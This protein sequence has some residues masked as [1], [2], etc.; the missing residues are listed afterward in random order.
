MLIIVVHCYSRRYLCLYFFLFC[1]KLACFLLFYG[2]SRIFWVLLFVFFFC[3]QKPAYEMRISDWSS[4]V[5]SSDLAVADLHL[6]VRPGVVG[7]HEQAAV[8]GPAEGTV[9][10]LAVVQLQAITVADGAL[11]KLC[12]QFE[13]ERPLSTASTGLSMS[14]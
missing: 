5:C 1:F 12:C 7:G 6:G 8:A 11:M 2:R 4:D 10:V 9:E 3:K 14:L 13:P